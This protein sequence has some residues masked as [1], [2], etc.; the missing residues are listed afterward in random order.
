MQPY[1][2]YQ[3]TAQPQQP[4]TQ[5]AAQPQQPADGLLQVQMLIDQEAMQIL[6]ESSAV[7]RESIVNLGIKLFSKTNAY[8]EFMLKDEFKK[9]DITTENLIDSISLE[10]NNSKGVSTTVSDTVV[11]TPPSTGAG[12]ASW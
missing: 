5:P 10:T 7:H 4:A 12:F 6:N 3:P 9:E 2:P 1:Q 11:D 8:K